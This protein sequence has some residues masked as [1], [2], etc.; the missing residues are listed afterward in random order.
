VPY[1]I[2]R[3]SVWVVEPVIVLLLLTF[4]HGR[5]ETRTD[6]RLAAA[7]GI[8]VATLYLPTAVLAP[9]PEPTPWASCHT[10][11][12]S[13]AFLVSSGA[14]SF[15]D[16]VVRPLRESLSVVL[17]ACVAV[18]VARRALRADELMRRMVAP[19]AL[20][21]G[22]RVLVFGWYVVSRRSG[23]TSAFA[24]VAG[25]AFVLSLP[26][27]T[28][29]FAAGLL[30]RR[31]FAADAL[32]RL[33][34]TISAR[35]TPHELRSALRNALKDPSL[36]ILYSMPD[37]PSGWVDSSGWPARVEA[38]PGRAIMDIAPGGERLAAIV[39]DAGLCEDPALLDS[40]RAY[41]VATLE[42]RQLVGQLRESLHE[43]SASRTRIVA[44]A[45]QERR[46]IERDLHDG[47]QQRLV[48]LQIK[49]ELLAEHIELESPA[50]AEEIR[51]F[52][53][54]VEET[55]DQVRR[56][57]RGVYPP[58][59]A[60]RGLSDALH[61]VARSAAIPTVID[62][63][64]PHRYSRE[65]EA[66]VYFSCLEAIQN[67]TKHARGATQIRIALTG[68]G[69][70]RFDVRDNGGGFD[71][72]TTPRG[73]GVTNMSD[74]LGAVDGTLKIESSARYGTHVMGMIPL[75]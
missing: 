46:R 19:V 50:N 22:V 37:A 31:L 59:L 38:G 30:A 39:H 13:N 44:A 11:C 62:A 49:L 63:R 66:A 68:N 26:A 42:T 35:P 17:F 18:V 74:R 27:V 57:G 8:L 10:S 61:A 60:D 72:E 4:P 75:P 34:P 43:L 1:S 56:F 5:L 33:T 29:A 6:R 15:V 55:L 69:S 58:L 25:T 73:N 14:A 65:V 40:V 64:L 52:E 23:D 32:E 45:D 2:G 71:T 3:A 54:D 51:A 20:V 7:A 21:A 16:D 47:A 41:T 24:D 9:Y 12:P 70:L 36:E 28:L 48:A 53:G 67:A